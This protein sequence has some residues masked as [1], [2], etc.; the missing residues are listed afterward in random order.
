M[1]LCTLADISISNYKVFVIELLCK[2]SITIRGRT[3][4]KE[5][6][7]TVSYTRGVQ[8]LAIGRRSAS[9]LQATALAF[10]SADCLNKA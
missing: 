8:V 2:Y 4:R 3:S 5:K 10:C 7:E 9:W 1:Y 6:T